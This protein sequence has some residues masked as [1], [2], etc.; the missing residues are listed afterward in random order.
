MKMKIKISKT[1][2]IFL[3][4]GIFVILAIGLVM[5][6]SQNDKERSRLKEE[7]ASAQLKL[8][9]YSAQELLS[10][11]KELE[12]R[13]TG[14]ESQLTTAKTSLY[15][16][17]ESIADTSTLFNIATEC[18]EVEVTK[19]ESPGIT[20]GNIEKVTLSVLPITITIE[21][22]VL[23]LIDFIH[24]WTEQYPTGMPKSVEITVPEP[25]A[26]ETETEQGKPSATIGLFIHSFRG[27]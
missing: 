21:G 3:V 14:A 22:E 1:T 13:L 27:E 23:K 16:S 19:I 24:K 12:S 9:K 2:L 20:T 6:Y 10:Q 26:D 4:G 5:T 8:K 11:K 17:I 18:K 7:V 15:Q 25:P